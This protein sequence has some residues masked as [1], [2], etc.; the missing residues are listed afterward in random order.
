MLTGKNIV[1]TGAN[2][3]IGK[4]VVEACARS[5]ANVWACMRTVNEASAAWLTQLE[6]EGGI[7]AKPVALDV[8]DEESIRAASASILAEKRPIDGLVNNAGTTG[9]SRLFSMTGME[10]LKATFEVNLFGP[11]FFT[12]R[13]LRSM[14]RNKSGSIV[15]IA[16]AA[17]LDGEPAQLP[18]VASKAAVIG[19]AR[20]LASELAP[21]HI[22]VNA[23]AP[24]IIDTDMGDQISDEATKR[25]LS[26]TAM[27][28][29]G[30][31]PE[32]ADLVIYLLSDGASYMTGQTLRP[33]GGM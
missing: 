8:S 17:A 31:A 4:A 13:L 24:G 23:V 7:Q 11:L 6:R 32:V 10:E 12:Q 15:N 29:K 27:K 25:T 1:V 26:R 5:G 30:T 16:S 19:A 14:I 20:K 9:P 28:R 21:F 2:R 3:G 18:Y 22:R 33:D